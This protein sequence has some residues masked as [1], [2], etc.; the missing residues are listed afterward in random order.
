MAMAKSYWVY[1]DFGLILSPPSTK[2][3]KTLLPCQVLITEGYLQEL[4]VNLP[5][6]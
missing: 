3:F 5:L 4:S 6:L 1:L 2:H